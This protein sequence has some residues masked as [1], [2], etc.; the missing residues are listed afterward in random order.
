MTVPSYNNSEAHS[1]RALI[2]GLLV[3]EIITRWKVINNANQSNFDNN[4]S[5][6][7]WFHMHHHTVNLINEF[8]AF[9]CSFIELKVLSNSL[10]SIVNL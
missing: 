7:N 3:A 9:F 5:K 8:K 1:V 6:T 2:L 4:M 10:N